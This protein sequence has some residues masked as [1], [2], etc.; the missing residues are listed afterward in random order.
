MNGGAEPKRLATYQVTSW[1]GKKGVVVIR[2][3]SPEKEGLG[4]RRHPGCGQTCFPSWE[5]R[6]AALRAR[7]TSG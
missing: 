6:E 4:E 5:G 2:S 3:L 1:G 7:V